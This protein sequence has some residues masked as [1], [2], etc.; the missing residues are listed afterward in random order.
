MFQ[1]WIC[2]SEFGF[3]SCFKLGFVSL[4]SDPPQNQGSE[5]YP[6]NNNIFFKNESETK[7]QTTVC[8]RSFG[9]FFI[10]TYYIQWVKISWTYSTSRNSAYLI[11][12]LLFQ[13]KLLNS[14]SPPPL[15]PSSPSLSIKDR[16]DR[17]NSITA[18]IH[19]EVTTLFLK[20]FSFFCMEF[21]M[22]L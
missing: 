10:V 19:N 20:D 5:Q 7:N 2:V 1:V 21:I 18:L 11:L 17:V 16:T 6:D 22:K 13:A 4:N 8:P 15:P 14:G 3:T 9:R 12:T